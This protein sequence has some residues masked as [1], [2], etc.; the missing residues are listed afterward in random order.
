METLGAVWNGS[1]ELWGGRD[2]SGTL[3]VVRDGLL[4]SRGSLGRVDGPLKRSGT[5]Q[6]TLGE[7]RDV[8]GETRGGLGQ[9]VGPS[10]ILN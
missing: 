9:I 2:R 6:G 8:L 3:G 10:G 1:E 7:I 4:D 5:V